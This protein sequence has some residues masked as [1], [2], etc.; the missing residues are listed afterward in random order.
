MVIPSRIRS[1]INWITI[2]SISKK[3]M[4]KV[5]LDALPGDPNT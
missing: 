2:F 4:T 1:T 5:L 3:E